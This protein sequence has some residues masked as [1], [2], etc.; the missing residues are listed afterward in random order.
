MSGAGPC[1]KCSGA[2]ERGYVVDFGDGGQAKVSGWIEG[3]PE[4]SI[5]TGLKMKDRAR[6]DVETWRCRRC[7]YL[8][9]YAR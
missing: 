6:Y 5:W 7:G 8:E 3:E 2:M 9:S 1:P 4:K